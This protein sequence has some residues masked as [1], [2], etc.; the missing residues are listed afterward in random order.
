[1]IAYKIFKE[2]AAGALY[3]IWVGK[4]FGPYPLGYTHIPA[5]GCGPF[6]CFKSIKDAQN[7]AYNFIRVVIYK[8]EIKKSNEEILWMDEVTMRGVAPEG[9]PKGTI[10]ADEFE[11]LERVK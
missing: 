3:P 7:F 1:M 2:F 9:L 11:I 4:E 8:V 5:D 10:L 6:A